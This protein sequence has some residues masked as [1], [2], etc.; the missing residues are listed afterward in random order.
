M[1]T[2]FLGTPRDL[3]MDMTLIGSVALISAANVNDT[4]KGRPKPKYTA[5]PIIRNDS[6][7]PPKAK[8]STGLLCSL[9]CEKG[10]FRVASPK[11]IGR[12][13][14]MIIA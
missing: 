9:K 13:K 14:E 11:R 1:V 4:I 2:T 6:S 5:R 8:A 10:S 7:V 12:N 3:K